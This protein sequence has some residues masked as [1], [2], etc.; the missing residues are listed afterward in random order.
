MSDEVIICRCEEISEEEIR[1]LARSG[2]HT[3]SG[4][5]RRIRAGMGLCQGRTCQRIIARIISEETGIPVCEILP[6]TSRPPCR[7]VKLGVLAGVDS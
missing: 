1:S 7:P 3:L 2:V 4:M 6:N 5:K